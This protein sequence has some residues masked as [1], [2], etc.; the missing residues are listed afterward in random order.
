M[1]A[2]RVLFKGVHGGSGAPNT[3]TGVE[4]D[5]VNCLASCF[6]DLFTSDTTGSLGLIFNDRG[7]KHLNDVEITAGAPLWNGL[8][9][10]LM[11]SG[12]QLVYTWPYSIRGHTGFQNQLFR[13]TGAAVVNKT[14]EYS[15]DTGAGWTAWTNCT[16]ANLSAETISPAGFKF[17][18]RITATGTINANGFDVRTTTTIA[19]QKANLYPLDVVPISVQVKD[20]TTDLPIEN[21]RVR[22]I[23]TTGSNVILEGL[24]NA[25]GIITSNTEYAGLTISGTVRRA[26]VAY[27]TIYKPSAISGIIDST[28]GFST[29]VLMISD[30]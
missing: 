17:R 21:A 16:G 4:G 18:V 26:S 19:D 11:K 20:L 12:D 1:D 22:I 7:Q 15:I 6:Y 3:T 27:G 5:L 14:V 28:T 25:S 30:E 2:T 10:L 13:M 29:T 23:E 9:D 24:T 8:G